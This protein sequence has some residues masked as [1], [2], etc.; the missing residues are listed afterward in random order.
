MSAIDTVNHV[1]VANFYGLPVYWILDE[2]KKGELT[3]FADETETLNSQFLSIGGG[4]GEHPAL[5]IDI[6]NILLHLF[7]QI[8]HLDK[9]D[10]DASSDEMEDYQ[11]YQTIFELIER[12]Y[13]KIN[14]QLDQ[15]QWPLETF[16]KI[17]EKMS[18]YQKNHGC[19]QS[20]MN[21]I[22]SF[23]LHEL[24]LQKCISSPEILVCAEIIKSK[25]WSK[26]FDEDILSLSGFEGILSCQK[27]GRTIKD[28]KVV[29]GYSMEDWRKDQLLGTPKKKL[30]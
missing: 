5:I 17:Y 3:D 20:M 28:N 12:N 6:E 19:L 1:H 8:N 24:P 23:C 15:N 16:F 9:P 11:A 25:S 7:K 27:N 4:S 10:L 30:R 21:S 22:A 18:P 13:N 26:L 14:Y 29:W 2:I